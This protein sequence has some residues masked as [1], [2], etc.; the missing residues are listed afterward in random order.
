MPILPKDLEIIYKH[1]DKVSKHKAYRVWKCKQC[2]TRHLKQIS[3]LSKLST[4]TYEEK[5]GFN[6]MVCNTDNLILDG[7]EIIEGFPY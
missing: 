1:R 6:C 4:T 3:E 2:Y 7:I 5:S